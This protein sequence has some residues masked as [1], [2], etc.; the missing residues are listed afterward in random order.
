MPPVRSWPTDPALILLERRTAATAC[1]MQ[2]SRNSCF[3]FFQVVRDGRADAEDARLLSY[4]LNFRSLQADSKNRPMMQMMQIGFSPK[5]VHE[6]I[7]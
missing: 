1:F 2:R 3:L 5:V 4:S 6:E 7:L